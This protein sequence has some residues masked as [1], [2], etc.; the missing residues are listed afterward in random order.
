MASREAYTGTTIRAGCDASTSRTQ[1]SRRALT[2]EERRKL[3]MENLSEAHRIA[4]QIHVRLPRYVPFDDLAHEGVVGLIDAVE[5]YD[6]IKNPRFRAYARL[7]IRGA[8]LDSLRGLDWGP[9]QLRRQARRIER[10]GSELAYQLGRTPSE[11]ELAAELGVSLAEFQRILREIHCL[12][13][14][15]TQALPELSSKRGVSAV[16][17]NGA[18]EDP[19]EVCV[20]AE[21]SRTLGRAIETLREKEQRALALYYFEERTMKEI[22]RVLKVQESRVSQIITVALCRLRGLME[23]N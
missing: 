15:T 17:L 10:A 7:R 12:T 1:Y 5:K 20:R 13:V 8:I 9:R 18:Q 22:G 3:L 4:R 21:T 11:A 16:P 23:R 2:P 14:E 6:P 19:F